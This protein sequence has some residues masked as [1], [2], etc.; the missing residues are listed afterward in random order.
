MIIR[1][2]ARGPPRVSPLFTLDGAVRRSKRLNV[3]GWATTPQ[4]TVKR[5]HGSGF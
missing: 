1:P 4:H 5:S 2:L 3:R